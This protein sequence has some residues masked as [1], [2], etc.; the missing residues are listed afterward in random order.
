MSSAE[1][2][3]VVLIEYGAIQRPHKISIRQEN[4][5]GQRPTIEHLGKHRQ[6]WRDII[7]GVNDG[8]ISTFLLV[9]GVVG[10][11]LSPNDILLTAIAGALAGAVSMSAGEFIATKSQN[12]VVQ[13][14]IGLERQ[15][16]R[17]NIAAE[18]EE[19]NEL[20]GVIGIPAEMGELRERLLN[21]YEN[22]DEALLK[23]MV[24]LEFG[25]VEDEER[26]PILAA[27]VSGLLFFAG[28]LPSLLPFAIGGVSPWYSLYVATFFVVISLLLIGALKTWATRGKCLSAALENL[29]VAGVGGVLAFYVG[30]FFDQII[31]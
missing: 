3:Q 5:R 17:H 18:M 24:A 14:E 30:A 28:S 4:N 15:H 19:V 16:I 7:L 1:N 22:N 23:L 26:S 6:Y 29:I 20:L 8:L 27:L 13:G 25:F 9:S 21:H 12:E 11:G 10:S 31:E 2:E